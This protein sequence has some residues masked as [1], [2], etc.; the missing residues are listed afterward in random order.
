MINLGERAWSLLKL[1]RLQQR[2]TEPLRRRGRIRRLGFPV[3]AARKPVARLRQCLTLAALSLSLG[4][5]SFN[6]SAAEREFT[7]ENG[8]YYKGTVV[9]GFRTGQGLY[10]WADK[11]RYEGEFLENRMHGQGIYT[12]PDGRTYRG[13]FVEDRREGQGVLTWPNGNRYEG[14]FRDNQMHGTG[15][16]TWANQDV[17]QGT[18]AADQRTGEGTF[19]WRTGEVY[20]GEFRDG[21]PNG[22]GFFSWPDGRTFEGTFVDGMKSGYG[23]LVSIPNDNRYEGMFERDVRSGLGVFRSRDGTIYRG[24]FADDKMHGYVV[25]QSPEGK[26]E[27]QEWQQGQLQ[28]TRALAASMRCQLEI[29]GNAWMFESDDCVNGLAHGYGLAARLDGLEI[30]V[31]GRV[32]LGRLIEG[33][34]LSLSLEGD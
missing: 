3:P 23:V 10:I 29:D 28:L 14:D 19:T 13:S 22:R 27:L 7:L 9:D 26:L 34:V 15:T 8:D 17:Y 30:I 31:D 20:T 32:V 21:V 16:F 18:F 25:K 11:R 6:I 12:W 2:T 4:L 33:D 1:R 24:Q 5:L